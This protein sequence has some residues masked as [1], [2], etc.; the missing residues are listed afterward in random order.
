MLLKLQKHPPAMGSHCSQFFNGVFVSTATLST[1]GW[2]NKKWT[3]QSQAQLRKRFSKKSREPTVRQRRAA[4]SACTTTCGTN[5]KMPQE[6]VR[7]HG[8]KKGRG[9]TVEPRPPATKNTKLCKPKE[10]AATNGKLIFV[11]RSH[12]SSTRKP[13][14]TCN[15]VAKP[16]LN[17]KHFARENTAILWWHRNLEENAGAV[18]GN[19]LAPYDQVL[20]AGWEIEFRLP[21]TGADFWFICWR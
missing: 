1:A 15:A 13:T 17:R 5:F 9:F 16:G 8:R 20:L 12:T 4:N 7:V 3:L 11:K 2:H 21:G 10:P 6:K 14:A 18:T 19:E